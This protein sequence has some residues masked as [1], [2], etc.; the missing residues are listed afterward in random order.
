MPG[1]RPNCS[2]LHLFELQ[3]ELCWRSLQRVLVTLPVSQA[4]NPP[5]KL[6]PLAEATAMADT[7]ASDASEGTVDMR[8]IRAGSFEGYDKFP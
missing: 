6:P 8:P 4:E 5:G 2:C 7:R 1:R 3:K